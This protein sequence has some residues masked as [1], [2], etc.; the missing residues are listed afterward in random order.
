MQHNSNL[1]CMQEFCWDTLTYLTSIFLLSSFF[2]SLHC[3]VIKDARYSADC[4]VGHSSKRARLL[5]R[6]ILFKPRI[7][8]VS[9]YSAWLCFINLVLRGRFLYLRR[10]LLK[11]NFRLFLQPKFNLIIILVRNENVGGVRSFCSPVYIKNII[12]YQWLLYY[13][14]LI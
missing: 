4:R 5:N 13:L 2:L 7:N 8:Q 10:N 14:R 1:Q 3:S 6:E 9:M 12:W 11:I